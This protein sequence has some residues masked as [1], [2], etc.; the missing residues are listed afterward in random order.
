MSKIYQFKENP[1]GDITLLRVNA[2]IGRYIKSEDVTKDAK[3][4]IIAEGDQ[5]SSL[6]GFGRYYVYVLLD[7]TKNPQKVFYVGKGTINRGYEHVQAAAANIG[8]SDDDAVVSIGVAGVDVLENKDKN[9]ANEHEKIKILMSLLR[10]GYQANQI[11]RVV[12]RNLSE[13]VAFAL[14]ALLIKSVYGRKNLTN[15][16][17]GQDSNRFRLID[18]WDYIKGFDLE[19]D[20]KCN[21]IDDPVIPSL[22][23]YV[24]VLRDPQEDSVFY[25]GKGTKG[26]LAQHFRDAAGKKHNNNDRLEEI[27][28]LMKAGFKACDIGRIIARVETQALAFMVESFYMKFVVGFSNLHNVQS[29][30][31]F[32]SFRS[33]GDWECRPGFDIPI[34]LRKGAK[35]KDLHNLFLGEGLD[36][37][38]FEVVR[39]LHKK[40]LNNGLEFGDTEI[41]G[42]GELI[43]SA[44]IPDLEP[45]PEK[46]VDEYRKAGRDG[47]K[48]LH[49]SQV[50]E[51]RVRVQVRN[52]REFQ[53]VL[54]S[55]RKEELTKAWYQYHFMKLHAWPV[56]RR[57]AQYMP[58]HWHG[59]LGPIGVTP[60]HEIAADRVIELVRIA[61]A[62]SREELG[63]IAYLLDALPDVRRT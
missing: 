35:R 44:R 19:V 29:G 63:N 12:G 52:S 9:D 28:R 1:N 37:E 36:Q 40:Y 8:G 32:G 62:Q 25:V 16:A 49:G 55:K 58:D 10:S 17:D 46:I 13:P 21:Y 14:E 45:L 7:P 27:R 61:K 39:I 4:T 56:R 26:R 24:Y 3:D 54:F 47:F 59:T 30:H 22:P 34:T 57:D 41:F 15:R 18:H 20:E 43:V 38:L 33:C 48:T 42:A 50:P 51:L 23:Y 31:V 53:V 60:I 11:V 2:I 5:L 6:L